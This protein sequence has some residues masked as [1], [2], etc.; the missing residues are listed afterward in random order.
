MTRRSVFAAISALFCGG[1]A[2][3]GWMKFKM[4]TLP[5]EEIKPAAPRLFWPP[6]PRGR[7][8]NGRIT[9]YQYDTEMW[10]LKMRRAVAATLPPSNY[11][12]CATCDLPW[13]IVDGHT[14]KVSE[15]SGLFVCCEMC[16]R[17]LGAARCLPYYEAHLMRW[18][19]QDA[20]YQ[21][22]LKNLRQNGMGTG[23]V[24]SSA[25]PDGRPDEWLMLRREPNP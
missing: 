21:A 24:F 11:S 14:I 3:S 20:D 18:C 5:P 19:H 13:Y 16:W 1:V 12:Q 8:E 10:A 15:S 17:S 9:M 6:Q 7:M 2:T 23:F 22:Q 25:A 4:H